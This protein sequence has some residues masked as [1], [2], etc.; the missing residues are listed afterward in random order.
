MILEFLAQNNLSVHELLG[1]IES[2]LGKFYYNRLDLKITENQKQKVLAKLQENSITQIGN[3]KVVK[4]ETLDGFKFR[5][6]EGEWVMARLSG[7]EP[8][9]RIYCESEKEENVDLH[10]SHLKQQLGV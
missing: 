7:T 4:V 1:E 2:Y 3:Y 8:L 5:L 9:V 10:I 6:A